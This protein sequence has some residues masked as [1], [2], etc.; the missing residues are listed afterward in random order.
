MKSLGILETQPECEIVTIR[1]SRHRDSLFRR[2]GLTRTISRTG[3]G[4][5]E[6]NGQRL[7]LLVKSFPGAETWHALSLQNASIDH[8]SDYL[9]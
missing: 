5:N 6:V 1:D 4:K 7:F 3:I 9:T 2:P 8:H